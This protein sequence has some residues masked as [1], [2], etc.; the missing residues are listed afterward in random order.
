[1]MEIGGKIFV[2]AMVLA[3]ILVGLGLFL[4][5]LENKLGRMEKKIS[6]LEKRNEDAKTSVN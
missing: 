5:Y 3:F 1:M 4:F 6:Q 2:V